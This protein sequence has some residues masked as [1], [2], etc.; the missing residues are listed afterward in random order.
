MFETII[1]A[2]LTAITAAGLK[3]GRGYPMTAGAKIRAPVVCVG[4]KS[5]ALKSSGCGEYLGVGTENGAETEIYGY[6]AE[7]TV[8][9]DL[10]APDAEK[11]AECWGAICDAL[12]D[13]PSGLKIRA[14]HCGAAEYD[15]VTESVRR[16]C[17]A[18]CLAY[19]TRTSAGDGE[20]FS[21]FVLRGVLKE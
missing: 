21:D 16:A 18:R 5:G 8:G 11:G 10:F 6:R 17:E 20:E 3:A 9:F 19:L 1:E 4:I 12:R 15:A 7:V 14:L 2:I 13:G